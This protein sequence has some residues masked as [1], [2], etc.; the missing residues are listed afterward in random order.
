MGHTVSV[1][2]R[3]DIGTMGKIYKMEVIEEKPPLYQISAGTMITM[4]HGHHIIMLDAETLADYLGIDNYLNMLLDMIDADD[5]TAEW[6]G[7][8][9]VE[10]HILTMDEVRC[11][12]D[13]VRMELKNI[14]DTI[15]NH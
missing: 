3:D 10:C 4:R 7:R 2:S 8:M 1:C 12:S 13:E 14:R 5:E 6:Y 11:T 9:I 15:I